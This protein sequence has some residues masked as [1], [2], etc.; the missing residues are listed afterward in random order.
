MQGAQLRTERVNEA[1]SHHSTDTGDHQALCGAAWVVS[2]EGGAQLEAAS[3]PAIPLLTA[4]GLCP[5]EVQHITDMAIMYS[6][7]IGSY[8][9][10]YNLRGPEGREGAGGQVR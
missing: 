4:S 3:S 7:F 9:L 1:W 10:C 2:A 5:P 6:L 8:S